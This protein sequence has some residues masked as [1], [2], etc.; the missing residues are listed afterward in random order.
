MSDTCSLFTYLMV[1]PNLVRGFLLSRRERNSTV[2][3]NRQHYFSKQKKWGQRKR[4]DVL[5]EPFPGVDTT[6]GARMR[7]PQP[8]PPS[9]EQMFVGVGWHMPGS[10]KH[11][12]HLWVMKP[13][14]VKAGC[15]GWKIQNNCVFIRVTKHCSCAPT[16]EHFQPAVFPLLGQMLSFDLF[17]PLMFLMA[18]AFLD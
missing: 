1:Q 9:E 5:P 2:N 12:L 16:K 15:C 14:K 13:D 3:E 18:V 11:Q 6:A 10:K 8:Q 17:S 7:M 4:A